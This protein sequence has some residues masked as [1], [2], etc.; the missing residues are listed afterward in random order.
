MTYADACA[1][2]DG[3]TGEVRSAAG[4]PLARMRALLR[5]LGDPQN[6]YPSIHVGGTSGKGSTAAMIASVLQ[7]AGLKT[8][9]HVKPHLHA[10]TER[11]RIDGVP[12]TQERFAEL[13]AAIRRAADGMRLAP[14]P[15]TYYEATL[16]LAF[17]AFA[18]EKVDVA[19]V[20]VGLGGTSD[21]TNVLAPVLSVITN[22]GLDHT[23][24]LGETLEAIARDK[25]GIAKSGVPLVS[26]VAPGEARAQVA[27]RCASVG[28]PLILVSEHARIAYASATAAAQCFHVATTRGDYA[29]A[30]PLFGEMQRRNAATAILALEA[31]PAR[32]RPEHAAIVAGLGLVELPGRM[33]IRSGDPT[34]VFDIAHN[35]EKAAALAAALRERFPERRFVFVLAVAATKDAAGVLRS[36]LP[37]AERAFCTRFGRAGREAVAPGRLAATA[38][39]AGVHASVVAT[40]HAAFDAARAAAP[41]GGIV[42]VTGSTFLVG[43][44]R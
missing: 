38:I 18:Q 14:G 40:P 37:L 13:T 42:V 2:L 34:V 35:P 12:I 31:L 36:L 8:A 41:P 27:L 7:A 29:V 33:E 3:L 26:D 1:Y 10:P 5:A 20:E 25:A 32:L 19:V 15:P 9:L 6:V 22:V 24:I 28:A 21:G 39:A 43:E 23:E 11:A 44:L 30:L 16:A 17:L 4:A